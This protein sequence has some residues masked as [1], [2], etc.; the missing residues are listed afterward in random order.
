M[1]L[2]ISIAL[3]CVLMA[4]IFSLAITVAYRSHSPARL[5][6]LYPLICSF[7][8]TSGFMIWG[9]FAVYI[10]ICTSRAS[11]AGIGLFFLPLFSIA[12]AVA[13]IVVSWSCLYLAHFIIDRLKR[14]PLGITS[15]VF[16]AL[17]IVLLSLTGYV[18][19]NRVA[20]YRLLNKAASGAD[21]NSLEKI[22]SDGISCQDV[23]VLSKLAKNPN[24]PI[25]DLV[26]LYDFC[27]PNIAKSSPPE[28]PVL[29]SLAR[30]SRTPPDILVV[31]AGCHPSDIRSYVAI[32][33]RQ[34]L[35]SLND[36]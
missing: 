7:V 9:Y 34:L 5:F 14:I 2:A 13:A 17:A 26:R 18:V 24:T 35:F 10:I 11:L 31:L 3:P 12:V 28:Y 27:N 8:I 16:L 20:R 19:Q 36:N 30:N 33:R 22:L 1:W 29:V 25:S 15:I 6:L 23:E 4:L 32:V 21:A